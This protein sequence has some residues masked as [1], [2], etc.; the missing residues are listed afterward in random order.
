MSPENFCYWLQGFFEIS[1]LNELREDQVKMVK[2]HL[3]LVFNKKTSS[4]EDL[5]NIR[6][7]D[8]YE[9]FDRPLCGLDIKAEPSC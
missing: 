5:S 6:I 2:E 7:F 3:Q 9:G 1:D 8:R 4:L